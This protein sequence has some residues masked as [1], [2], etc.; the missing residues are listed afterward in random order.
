MQIYPQTLNPATRGLVLTTT[1]NMFSLFLWSGGMFMLEMLIAFTAFDLKS[2]KHESKYK[3]QAQ[4]QPQIVVSREKL[5]RARAISNAETALRRANQRRRGQKSATKHPSWLNL[6]RHGTWFKNAQDLMAPATTMLSEGFEFNAQIRETDCVQATSHDLSTNGAANGPGE[7]NGVESGATTESER[8]AA[9]DLSHRVLLLLND[10]SWEEV[11]E[12]CI[13]EPEKTSQTEMM[14]WATTGVVGVTA[15][16]GFS[17]Y[18]QRAF[19]AE[20]QHERERKGVG[21][22]KDRS[23][24]LANVQKTPKTESFPSS[25]QI[26]EK[27]RCFLRDMQENPLSDLQELVDGF[28]SLHGVE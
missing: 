16:E 23:A 6:T 10:R 8:E 17:A 20:Q 13:P 1:L 15:L 26:R 27:A 14:R 28:A 7:L 11:P 19:E 4:A 21:E 24:A 18:L 5:N 22:L 9:D 3:A 25:P 12:C 2:S